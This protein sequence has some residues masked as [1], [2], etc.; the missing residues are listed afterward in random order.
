MGRIPRTA[1]NIIAALTAVAWLAALPFGGSDS[2][3]PILG[4]IPARVLGPPV[5]WAAAP[6]FLTPLSATLVHANWVHV[7]FN[8]LFLIWT[9][10]AVERVL[11]RTGLIVLYVVGAYAA[12][13]GQWAAD[14]HSVIPMVGASGAISAVIGAFSLSFGRPKQFTRSLRVNRWI[15]AV[16]LLASWVVLQIMMGWLAGGQGYLLAWPAH[17]GGFAAGILLQRPLLL[18]HYRHA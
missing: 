1:T 16:W 18:W 12:A 11:G 9:G 4:F 6:V 13:A 15:N 8:L 7:G 5:P 3:G 14:P 17:V 10:H 2:V